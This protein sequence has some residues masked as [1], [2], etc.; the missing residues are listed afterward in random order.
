VTLTDF[1]GYCKREPGFF[2]LD[3]KLEDL[4]IE[5]ISSINI[6]VKRINETCFVFNPGA[7]ISKIWPESGNFHDFPEFNEVR[8]ELNLLADKIIYNY[9]ELIKTA[10]KQL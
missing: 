4:R 8:K 10:R 9:D 2:F 7:E 1:C 6:F 5:L 3:G